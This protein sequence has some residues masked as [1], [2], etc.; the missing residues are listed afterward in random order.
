ML[1]SLV[2][3]GW[4][5]GFGAYFGW[6]A[7]G[8]VVKMVKAVV[9]RG[10]AAAVQAFRAAKSRWSTARVETP[11]TKPGAACVVEFSHPSGCFFVMLSD[12]KPYLYHP[13]GRSKPG[14]AD[15]AST[16]IRMLCEEI[17]LDVSREEL[18]LVARW[19]S[20]DDGDVDC[21]FVS[22]DFARVCHLFPQEMSQDILTIAMNRGPNGIRSILA[23]PEEM[24]ERLEDHYAGR[25]FSGRH[26]ACLHA[27]LRLPP[28][29]T[30]ES[31]SFEWLRGRAFAR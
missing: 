6:N 26:R 2:G 12:D 10:H 29:P 8:L 14:D 15:S 25:S 27:L 1:A 18:E 17:R 22:V 3:A 5:A 24:V 9:R 19:Q 20:S 30:A 7:A 4:L 28:V 23:I 13:E 21:F 11:S 16:A 31:E